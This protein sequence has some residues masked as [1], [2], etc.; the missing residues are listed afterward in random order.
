MSRVASDGIV[1]FLEE[2]LLLFEHGLTSCVLLANNIHSTTNI[3]VQNNNKINSMYYYNVFLSVLPIR[4][5]GMGE[6]CTVISQSST[7]KKC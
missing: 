2:E 4:L 7:T 5:I 3:I 1:A 6:Q